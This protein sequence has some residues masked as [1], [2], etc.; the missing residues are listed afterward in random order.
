MGWGP[1][2]QYTLAVRL[3][4]PP[5]LHLTRDTHN[6]FLEVLTSTGLLGAIPYLLGLSMCCLAA[7]K[8]RRGTEGIL[9]AAQMAALLVG[10]LSGNYIMLK[11]Q[12]VL[13]A[14]AMASWT[15]L[16]ARYSHARPPSPADLRRARS[17]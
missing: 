4:L 3:G 17:G 9:P 10:N 13:L 11:L 16:T 12:W 1:A 7:W 8:A 2:N 6:L 15:Y 5:R 14:Y